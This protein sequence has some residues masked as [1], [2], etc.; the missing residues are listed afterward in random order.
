MATVRRLPLYWTVFSGGGVLMALEILASR[1]LAPYFGNSVYV[2]G[3]IISVFLAALSVGYYFGGKIADR[4]P[5]LSGLAWMV[6]L[7]AASVGVLLVVGPRLAS[8]FGEITDGSPWGTLVAAAVLFIPPSVLFATLS[9]YAVRLAAQDLERLGGTAGRLYAVSTVGS[10]LGTLGCTFGMIPYLEL[11]SS[12]ALLLAVTSATVLV[13]ALAAPRSGR[14][15][16]ALALALLVAAVV[17]R[18]HPPRVAG[19]VYE[20]ITPYQTLRVLDE[21]EVRVLESDRVRHGAIRR[22]DGEMV[23]RYGRS[24]PAALLLSPDIESVLVVGMGAGS[25][26][27]YFRSRIPTMEL[28]FVDVDPAVPEVA[29][30]FMGFE[31]GPGV[32]V[33]VM[34]GRRFLETTGRRW[35]LIVTD[36][37]IGLSVPF[38]LTTREY[39]ELARDHLTERGVFALNLAAGLEHPFSRA[40]ARTVAA[41]FPRVYLFH[42]PGSGNVLVFGTRGDHEVTPGEMARFADRAETRLLDG[43]ELDPSLAD[44]RAF[45]IRGGLD[46]SGVPILSDRFAPVDRLIH[47]TAD[48]IPQAEGDAAPGGRPEELAGAAR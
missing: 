1:I 12:L 13:P 47:M 25:V 48:E 19:L 41:V 8:T 21:G 44:L 42:A 14:V 4:K 3:S 32:R 10:L 17:V 26:A 16:V 28:D 24:F 15:V 30:R 2:W 35:D 36:A 46:F 31:E 6:L 23:L 5:D 9:P 29:R 40:M 18:P 43:A 37:Y 20:R 11:D 38:H 27:E 7:A 33:H 45:R 39:L 22:T 34:D